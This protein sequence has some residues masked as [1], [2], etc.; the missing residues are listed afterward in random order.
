M[1]NHSSKILVIESPNKVKT[2]KKY[3]TDDYEIVATVGHIRDLPKYTLGFN[4]EDFV[5]KW[6]IIQEKK[7]A[8]GTSATKKAK[9]VKK[10]VKSKKEIIDELV[11]KAK[12]ADEIYLATDPDREGEAIS[13]HVYDVL[14]EKGVN[15]NKCKRIIFNEISE[16]AVK[17]A[18]ANPR[19]IQKDWV[20]SQITRRRLDRLIGFKLSSLM[21]S[22]INADS[23]GR[24]QSIALK[25]ITEREELINKFV[26]RFWWT[27]DVILKDGTELMLRKIDEKL[28]DKLGY[29][30]LEEVSGIDFNTKEDAELVK[31]HLSDKYRVY[32]ID[33]PKLKS[34]YPKEVYKTSTLQQ[35]AI[36]KLKWRSMKITSVAQEL[37]EGVN[38]DDEQIALISYPRTDSTRL[39]PEYGKT[40]LDFVAKMYGKDYVATQS[41]LNGETKI[42]KKQ[43]AKVQDAHEAIHPI[44]ITITPD[45]VKNKISSDQYSLYK[46]IWTRTV[47]HYMAA[48]VYE[49][50]NIRFINNNNKFY[51]V[52]NTLKFDGYKKIYTH[53]DDKDHLR[54]LD[55]NHF[56]ID[57]EFEAK[58]ILLNEHQTKPPARFTQATLIEALETEGIGRPSTYSTIL[59]IVLKRNYAELVN[60]R[61]YKTTDLGQKLAFELDKNFPTIIN[62]E[63][64]KNMET[65]LDEIAQGTVNDVSYLQA[66]WN[67]FSEVLNEAKTNIVKKVE[68]IEGK[69]CPNCS[70]Q[71]VRREGRYGPFV[72]CSNFPKCKFIEKSEQKPKEIVY[73]EG[74]ECELCH[75]K[76]IRRVAKKKG[77]NKDNTFLGCSNFPK[78]KYTKSLEP[79]K[80]ETIRDS[81]II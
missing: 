4:T 12:K 56:A 46:L 9:T 67:D 63:F 79:E 25:F 13:W 18:I 11:D 16:K 36:N 45:S 72:G 43:K 55:L 51:A 32:A 68:Y 75:A 80:D 8:K 7:P 52:N 23:A 48:A 31:Q 2:I 17:N 58:D 10:A 42:N 47:A 30:E 5:P 44:D 37:Y 24:V 70:S 38:M 27:L 66:F 59:D 50:V 69:N 6:E 22:K 34:S 26:P 35:D 39:S 19:E 21:K 77:R 71:L 49:L 65:T 3:L 28:K 33:T 60:G 78:C 41:Q 57:K 14:K 61:Y 53:Y 81:T 76:L 20:S 1:T 73:E 54:K 64:T 29:K 15:V 40:V 74:V 62:K